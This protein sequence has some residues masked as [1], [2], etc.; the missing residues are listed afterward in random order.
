M[1]ADARISPV[2]PVRESDR[3]PVAEES[4]REDRPGVV[5]G[6]PG[7]RP[8]TGAEPEESEPG[9]RVPPDVIVEIAPPLNEAPVPDE[10]QPE[11][12]ITEVAPDEPEPEKPEP[13][14]V[15]TEV[16]PEVIPEVA[17]EVGPPEQDPS[18]P[19]EPSEVITEVAPEVG[20]AEEEPSKP[21]EP[22]DPSEVITE[23]APEVTPER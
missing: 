10:Q 7:Y 15:I 9:K 5:P 2:A 18:R 8:V 12:P 11:R 3:P 22:A 19:Y 21:Y 17:P 13:S 4:D 14:E 20:P 16:A 6:E 1:A 23:V